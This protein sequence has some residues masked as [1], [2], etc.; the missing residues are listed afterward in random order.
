MGLPA[1]MQ[2]TTIRLLGTR[3]GADPRVRF[4]GGPAA[5]NL[6]AEPLAALDGIVVAQ[7]RLA[8]HHLDDQLTIAS[9]TATHS[10]PTG[11]RLAP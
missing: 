2:R 10:R 9:A 11:G 5:G 1:S 8:R 6:I 3:L 4:L 7:R